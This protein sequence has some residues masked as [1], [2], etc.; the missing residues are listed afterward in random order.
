MNNGIFTPTTKGEL[1]RI[2]GLLG[3]PPVLSSEDEK[4]FGEV[5]YQVVECVEP[6]DMVE[7]IYLWHFV[8]ASWVISRYTRHGTVAVVRSA[9]QSR[10]FRAQRAKLRAERQ[11]AQ[12]SREVDKL[13]QSPTDVA[14]MV[15]L[16]GKFED[17]VADT[18][19]IF[20]TADL[21]REYNRALQ[22]SM[23]FQQQLDALIVSQT[24]IRD[25]AL[26]QLDLYRKGLGKRASD[27]TDDALK[28][29]SDE[30]G[31]T[32]AVDAPSIVPGDDTGVVANAAVNELPGNGSA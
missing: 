15:Q 9:Q 29:Q 11:R 18:D 26:R 8:C 22:Q 10:D 28:G 31:T 27:A 2:F 5:F 4:Q 1:S 16:E 30:Q 13:T 19:A 24:R 14:Q 21:E 7:M 12:M 20:D 17:M 32:D 3:K 23:V 25:E 6:C